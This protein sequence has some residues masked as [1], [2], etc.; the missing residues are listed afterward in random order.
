MES[1]PTYTGICM[2]N[3]YLYQ[4]EIVGDRLITNRNTDQIR[5]CIKNKNQ[6]SN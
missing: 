6:V 2:G 5:K 3:G 4:G 1:D